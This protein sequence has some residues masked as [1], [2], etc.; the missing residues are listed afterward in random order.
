MVSHGPSRRRAPASRPDWPQVAASPLM[1]QTRVP[2]RPASPSPH[3]GFE[4]VLKRAR[5]LGTAPFEANPP[6]LPDALAKLDFD[7]WRDIR[8]RRDKALLGSDGGPFRLEMFHLGHLYPRPVTVNIVREGIAT[9]VPYSAS[10]FDYGRNKID[11][12]LPRQPRLRGLPAAL[13]AQPARRARRGRRPSSAPAISASSAASSATACRPAASRSGPARRSEEFPFFREFWIETPGPGAE[14]VTIYALLDGASVDRRLPVRPLPRRE[15]VMEVSADAVPAPR[16]RQARHRAADLHVLHQPERPPL[17]RRLPARTARFR[18][19]ADPFGHRRMDLAAAAQ[20]GAAG[21]LGLPRQGACRASACCSATASSRTT[22]T[23]TS[24]TSCARATGSSRKGDWGDGRV[25]LVEL[26]TH[27]RDQRQYRG[28]LGAERPPSRSAS[29]ITYR[30]HA[31]PRASTSS[32]LSPGGRVQQDLP[33]PG[34]RARLERGGVAGLAP[35]HHRFLGR[36]PRLLRHRSRRS[37]RWCR[38]RPTAASP[39]PSWCPTRISTA[40]APPSTWNCRRARATDLRAFL[41]S[42]NRALTET[43]TFPWKAP[44]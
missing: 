43:W 2:D 25:E 14:R 40:S 15:T 34:P 18:R 20:P 9:P 39:A 38:P 17:L 3:F 5:E 10:L 28:L 30:L 41:K 11:K 31:S 24:P 8:F 32:R 36:R 27:G 19:A 12:P 35:L 7:A 13:P 42:G 23:S 26:P 44:G 6:P 33:D 29:R 22:R 4:D 21:G 1:A 37:C 16:R